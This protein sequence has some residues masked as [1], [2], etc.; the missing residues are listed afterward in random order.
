MGK[1]KT[2]DTKLT[3]EEALRL[4]AEVDPTAPPATLRV[5]EAGQ[6]REGETPRQTPQEAPQGQPTSAA[7]LPPPPPAPTPAA[8][9]QTVFPEPI[10]SRMAWPDT[11]QGRRTSVMS[12]RFHE[13]TLLSMAR[14]AKERGL[15]QKQLLNAA[16]EAMGIA[17]HPA[18][19]AVRPP[20]RRRTDEV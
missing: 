3:P 16:L 17:V 11:S 18:D 9:P 10:R 15:T 8:A 4:V 6:G 12:Y 1:L 20:P 13:E 14:V 5:P 2:R 7:A 19:N